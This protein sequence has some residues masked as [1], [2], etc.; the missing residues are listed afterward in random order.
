MGKSDDDDIVHLPGA[1]TIQ[2]RR[3]R[4]EIECQKI[5]SAHSSP[6]SNAIGKHAGWLAH[7][8]KGGWTM[9]DWVVEGL[10]LKGH[11]GLLVGDAGTG[12]S[13][14]ALD[15][16][17]SAVS[18]GKWLGHFEC[19]TTPV[20]YLAGEGKIDENT[21]H[22]FGLLLGRGENIPTFLSRCGN[23][24]QLHAPD[25]NTLT[26]EAPLSSGEWWRNIEAL[27]KSTHPMEA[28]PK[29]WIFDPLLALINSADKADDVRPFIARCRWL[30]EQTGGYVWVLHHTKK[31]QGGQ[32]SRAAKIRGESM[33]RNLFDDV[34]Y[35]EQDT[36]DPR[37]SHL[38]ANKLKRGPS[39]DTKP[40]C[41]ILRAFN[42]I[43]ERTFDGILTAANVLRTGEESP[44]SVKQIVLRYLPY[45][46]ELH[47][48][49]GEAA[50]AEDVEPPRQKKAAK[51]AA[52][53]APEKEEIDTSNWDDDHRRVW[54]ALLTSD[55]PL[56]ILKIQQVLDSDGGAR[57]ST[58][59]I[60]TRIDALM[61][62]GVVVAMPTV[63]LG[64]PGLAY[65]PRSRTL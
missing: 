39:D 5:W 35:L 16:L 19:L 38:Y 64:R 13:L 59:K 2:H 4:I 56:S 14:A 25:T 44:R 34:L 49:D 17:I 6:Y 58:T 33:L 7:A 18:G 21:S 48:A 11:I 23:R 24:V 65:T 10:F 57:A 1:W 9:E 54:Y 51:S 29:L 42:E 8:A 28:R 30:A 40:M 45:S 62:Q 27:V 60:Q 46:P 22:I 32:L 43:D 20:V 26:A 12:K 36:M 55:V 37:L 50:V 15:M 61:G 63:G 3:N 31:D 41:H 53:P 47:K 52:A